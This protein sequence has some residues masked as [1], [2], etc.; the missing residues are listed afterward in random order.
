LFG[1][2]KRRKKIE[3]IRAVM[4]MSV[5]EKIGREDRKRDG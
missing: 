5:R 1:Y 2:V 4:K 3:A